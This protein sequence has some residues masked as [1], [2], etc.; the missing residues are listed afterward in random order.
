MK[1]NINQ[2]DVLFDI[3]HLFHTFETESGESFSAIVKDGSI[4][5]MM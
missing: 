4:S 2:S 5:M 3:S 1:E